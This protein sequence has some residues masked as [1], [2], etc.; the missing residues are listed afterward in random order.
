MTNLDSVL[1]SRDITLLTKV[2]MVKA[3]SFPVVMYGCESWIIKKAEHWRIDAFELCCWR[4]LLIVLWAARSSNKSILKEILKSILKATR[5]LF[6]SSSPVNPKG[7]QP[8]KNWCWSWSL[9]TWCLAMWWEE[10]THLK[11]PLC[12]ERLKAKRKGGNRGW[13]G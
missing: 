1:K 12:W 2:H 13:D 4:R 7:N 10:Q 9:A 5:R 3:I 8:W 11:R 6:S